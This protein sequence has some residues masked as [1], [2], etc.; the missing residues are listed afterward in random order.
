ITTN[1]GLIQ[2]ISHKYCKHIH[3]KDGYSYVA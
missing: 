2:G 3:K 1:Q